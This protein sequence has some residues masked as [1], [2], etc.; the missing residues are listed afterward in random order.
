M[1]SLYYLL[2]VSAK[3]HKYHPYVSTMLSDKHFGHIFK[4]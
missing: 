4:K 3:S 2:L 1:E